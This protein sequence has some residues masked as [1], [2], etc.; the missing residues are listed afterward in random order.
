MKHFEAESP[1]RLDAAIA[2]DAFV[3]KAHAEDSDIL[4]E[5]FGC[6]LDLAA[7]ISLPLFDYL[8]RENFANPVRKQVRGYEASELSPGL[9]L[10]KAD[11]PLIIAGYASVEMIDREKHLISR[12]VLDK[13]FKE[14]MSREGRRNCMIAH[15]NVQ[16]GEIL[17]SWTSPRTGETYTSGVDDKGLFVVAKVFADTVISKRVAGEI[18]KG[19]L[20]AFSISGLA[21]NVVSKNGYKD[22]RDL[23]LAEITI[24]ETPVNPGAYFKLVKSRGVSIEQVANAFQ[25][26]IPL[27]WHV[28]VDGSVESF[29]GLKGEWL[30]R[31]LKMQI[32]RYPML[33]GEYE[34]VLSPYHKLPEGVRLSDY[35]VSLVGGVAKQGFSTH[36]CDLLIRH[37]KSST[38]GSVIYSRVSKMLPNEL[39]KSVRFVFDSEGP[40]SERHVPLLC[41]VAKR[42]G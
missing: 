42:C 2:I 39:R 34:L 16:V 13:A 18:T 26:S 38:L 37:S 5:A 6:D 23:E 3:H 19:T 41:L 22:V 31:A 1:S 21:R 12:E 24:C 8:A 25:K 40:H 9:I 7:D 27:N 10:L 30:E 20:S 15:S 33:H 29:L 35:S 36:D 28:K 4:G 17:D 14:F 32:G 11:E